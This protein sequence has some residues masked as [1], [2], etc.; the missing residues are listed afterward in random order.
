[1]KK[2]IVVALVLFAAWLFATPYLTLHSIKS[3]AEEKDIQSLSQYIDFPAFKES[4]KTNLKG[5]I[6]RTLAKTHNDNPYANLLDA[7]GSQLAVRMIDP[8]LDAVVTPESVAELLQ[9]NPPA[10]DSGKEK[11]K[12]KEGIGDVLSFMPSSQNVDVVAGY[13]SFDSFVITLKEKGSGKEVMAFIL[14]RQGLSS[15]R[16][17]GVKI[18]D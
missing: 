6:N 1:V 18:P 10:A 16:V 15:W 2:L 14:K 13:K 8:L 3:A 9:G 11:G 12:G 5:K 4:L 7:A 17:V